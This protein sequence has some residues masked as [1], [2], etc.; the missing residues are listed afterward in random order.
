MLP[1]AFT[2]RLVLPL[3]MGPWNPNMNRFCCSGPFSVAKGL[4]AFSDSSRNPTLKLPRHPP[5][6]GRV[7][8]S[9]R[10]MPAS[11]YSAA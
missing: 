2:D 5:I 1:S 4:R 6:P 9:M 11:W 8:T 3:A 7:M 10:T